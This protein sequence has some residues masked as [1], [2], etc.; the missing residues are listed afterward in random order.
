MK[1]SKDEIR[2]AVRRIRDDVLIDMG[3]AARLLGKPPMTVERYVVRGCRGVR[4]DG[5]HRPGVGWVTSAAAVERF[6][7]ELAERDGQGGAAA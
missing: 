2:R 4:L 6:A 5:L 1:T 7:R 3:E